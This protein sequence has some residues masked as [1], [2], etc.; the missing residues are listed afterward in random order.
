MS[1]RKISETTRDYPGPGSYNSLTTYDVGSPFSSRAR[2][3][4]L[5]KS[6][7]SGPGY[8]YNQLGKTEGPS[9]SLGARIKLSTKPYDMVGPGTYN[10]NASTLT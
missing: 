9:F 4:N 1:Q 10:T 5:L 7:I 2:F 8:K 3:E 6:S